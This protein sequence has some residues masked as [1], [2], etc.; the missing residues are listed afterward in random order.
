MSESDWHMWQS[1]LGQPF[2]MR[3]TNCLNIVLNLKRS[4]IPSAS[5]LVLPSSCSS[6]SVTHSDPMP[7][8]YTINTCLPSFVFYYVCESSRARMRFSFIFVFPVSGIRIGKCLSN[9]NI[10]AS[11]ME[12]FSVHESIL[13]IVKHKKALRKAIFHQPVWVGKSGFPETHWG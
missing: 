10:N 13:K 5:S 4:W 12:T 6:S 9:E 2:V 3:M 8:H 11:L 7:L 1:P